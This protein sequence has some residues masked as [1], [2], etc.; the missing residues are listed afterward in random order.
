VS[1]DWLAKCGDE[2]ARVDESRYS[3]LEPEKNIGGKVR[4]KPV[5]E[6]AEE[7]ADVAGSPPGS[8]GYSA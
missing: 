1:A 8:P 3:L 7:A 6:T 4:E 5:V 2:W